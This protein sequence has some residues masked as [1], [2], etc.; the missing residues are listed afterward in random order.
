MN[1][2]GILKDM[3]SQVAILRKRGLIPS[4]A[5]M[6]LET[7]VAIR[8]YVETTCESWMLRHPATYKQEDG[9]RLNG[10][11]IDLSMWLVPDRVLVTGFDPESQ[12]NPSLH[13]EIPYART[14]EEMGWVI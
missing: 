2:S 4:T 13:T 6:R 8:S 12:V 3:D 7:Y 10:L 9:P 5:A 11:L 14:F 1:V